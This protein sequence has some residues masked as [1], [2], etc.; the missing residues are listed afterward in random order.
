MT[1][2]SISGVLV[3]GL[4]CPGGGE[5]PVLGLQ[6]A[7]GWDQLPSKPGRVAS[8]TRPLLPHSVRKRAQGEP[9]RLL[10]VWVASAASGMLGAG[11]EE[12][13]QNFGTE[14]QALPGPT[15]VVN[16]KLG[17]FLLALSPESSAT[18]SLSLPPGQQGGQGS[19]GFPRRGWGVLEMLLQPP[20]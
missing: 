19:A 7:G 18:V 16:I 4:L 15:V 12:S 13:L 17:F 9:P 10:G 8:L 11:C 5:C 20:W 6:T 1:I 2:A 14:H 3:A